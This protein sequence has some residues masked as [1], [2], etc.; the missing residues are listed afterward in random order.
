MTMSQRMRMREH[1]RRRRERIRR[2][3]RRRNC[4]II[5][6]LL[7][8]L[9]VAVI[10]MSAN[11]GGE[12]KAPTTTA[13]PTAE[14]VSTN[15]PYTTTL[16]AEDLDSEFY[17]NAAFLGN[18]VADTVAMYGIL[19]DA[20]FYTYVNADLD[21]AYSKYRGKTS[22]SNQIKNKKFDKLFVS[23]G[24][25]ELAW[26][27]AEEFRDGYGTFVEKMIE[28]QP[29]CEIYLI[30]I[31]PVTSE[32]SD[33]GENGMT[34]D[35]IEEYNNEIK[36]IAAENDIFYIDSVEALGNGKGYLPEGVSKDGISL[37][38]AAVIDLLY[39]AERNAYT[40]DATD[41]E[42]PVKSD[43]AEDNSSKS[44]VNGK[45]EKTTA[46]PKAT[47]TPKSTAEPKTTSTPKSGTEK[48]QKKSDSRETEA[49]PE[50]T[51]NVLKKSV[52]NKNNKGSNE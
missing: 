33:S 31:P 19:P 18:A 25:K 22:I 52:T 40:P 8:A 6:I 30:G 43:E 7:A 45:G 20:D 51:V 29:D 15:N 36:H 14:Q 28:K 50:P 5:V 13:S 44:D 32:V 49:S 26:E 21:N 27:S 37:N 24:E 1:E 39:Y 2:A 3:R 11:K 17:E 9:A 47:S 10:V 42:T 41:L 35:N 46:S 38:K 23:F 16:T 4:A 48:T 12:S 34:M